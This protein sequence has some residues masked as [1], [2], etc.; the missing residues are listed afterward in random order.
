MGSEAAAKEKVGN[1][2][3]KE[4]CIAPSLV[5]KASKEHPLRS[6]GCQQHICFRMMFLDTV[7]LPYCQV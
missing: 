3:L 1:V 2:T 7:G 4:V 6:R 5:I